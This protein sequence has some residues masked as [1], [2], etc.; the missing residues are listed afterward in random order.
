MKKLLS[1]ILIIGLCS[2][3]GC[4]K[5]DISK[6]KVGDSMFS[7]IERYGSSSHIYLNTLRVF[8]DGTNYLVTI[9]DFRT[10]LGVVVFDSTGKL[11]FS[12]G[13][14][15]IKDE[16]MEQ[17]Q[18]ESFRELEKQFGKKHCDTGSG[19]Y[20]PSYITDHGTIVIIHVDNDIV[21][22]ISSYD[23]ITGV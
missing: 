7:V 21:S 13:V 18:G 8:R 15:P 9:S 2:A 12:E 3:F 19:F 5:N 22:S 23:V 6:T 11:L 1:V 17:F 4:S 10:V 14:T 20:Y 16:D